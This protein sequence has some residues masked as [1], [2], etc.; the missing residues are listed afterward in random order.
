M[1]NSTTPFGLRPVMYLNGRPY[2][3]AKRPYYAANNYATSLFIGDP[4]DLAGGCCT[5]TQRDRLVGTLP[6]ITKAAAGAT[7]SIVGSIVGFEP[8]SDNTPLVYGAAN[9][10]RIVWVADDPQIVFAIKDDGYQALGV[11]YGTKNSMLNISTA[12]NTGTGVSGVMM[13]AGTVTTPSATAN[14][15]L[16]M[17]GIE[18]V[19]E[20]DVTAAY[21]NWLVRINLHR[22][23]HA[24]ASV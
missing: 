4:V 19:A 3:G 14:G 10:H 12:G 1:A 16:T 8:V 11:T 24:S 13:D 7:N 5:T 17:M 9:T 15:Q 23:R 21:C 22:Y 20:N 6:M 18:A 2:D